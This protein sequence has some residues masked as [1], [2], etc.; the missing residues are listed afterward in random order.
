MPP[1][2]SRIKQPLVI[3]QNHLFYYERS[4][5]LANPL[6]SLPDDMVL[7]YPA[8]F[9]E[10]TPRM[11]AG[12]E[13]E[14]LGLRERVRLNDRLG[15]IIYN[16]K[17]T[18]RS[19]VQLTG[20][21]A[22]DGDPRAIKLGKGEKYIHWCE[23]T[24]SCYGLGLY[25]TMLRIILENLNDEPDFQKVYISCRQDNIGSIKGILKAGFVYLKSSRAISLLGGIYSHSSW[26]QHPQPPQ[27]TPD[28]KYAF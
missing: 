9:T 1:V 3:R 23:T 28:H 7:I 21:V 17:I 6:K 26:Y 5:P 8:D 16:G 15:V 4:M 11:F 18:H 25:S 19:A 13:F 22:M 27:L 2:L 20:M 14:Y 10:L 12:G 24:K